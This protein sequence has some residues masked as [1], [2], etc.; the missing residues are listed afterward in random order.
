MPCHTSGKATHQV[1]QRRSSSLTSYSPDSLAAA[2]YNIVS[3]FFI[4]QVLHLLLLFGFFFFDPR[5][6]S[7]NTQV[8]SS[9]HHESLLM[10]H[11]DNP[12]SQR[13]DV[14]HDATKS[15]CSEMRPLSL[16]LNLLVLFMWTRAHFNHLLHPR[17]P[18]NS[19]ASRGIG[20][21]P[22]AWPKRAVHP[23][24]TAH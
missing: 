17:A 3:L 14:F 12:P 21:P 10:S 5:Y 18:G 6:S 4:R 23:V 22:A 2:L 1:F 9:C 15:Q 16:L 20:C 8:T 13:M 11:E 24:Y 19:L 7:L